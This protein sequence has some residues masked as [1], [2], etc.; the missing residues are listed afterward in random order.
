MFQE[1][2]KIQ[3]KSMFLNFFY[4]FFKTKNRKNYNSI[5]SIN[6]ALEKAFR[7]LDGS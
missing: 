3:T 2:K 5:T 4:N 7:N 6:E 1:S